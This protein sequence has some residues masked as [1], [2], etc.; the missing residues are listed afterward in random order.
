M[1]V[2][3]LELGMKN[4]RGEEGGEERRGRGRKG[5]RCYLNKVGE[6]DPVQ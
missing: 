1:I 6:E 3:E 5:E 4:W 2:R